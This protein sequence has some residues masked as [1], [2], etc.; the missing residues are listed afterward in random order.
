MRRKSAA[1]KSVGPFSA[2][3]VFENGMPSSPFVQA[4]MKMAQ[5][6]VASVVDR[7][8]NRVIK[9]A[10]TMSAVTTKYFVEAS[11]AAAD[12]GLVLGQIYDIS[13]GSTDE[14]EIQMRAKF[15]VT[16]TEGEMV[17]ER[18]ML[19]I[20]QDWRGKL[21]MRVHAF[22]ELPDGTVV[23]VYA[24]SMGEGESVEAVVAS[25]K[26][27]KE[28]GQPDGEGQK[29]ET[30]AAESMVIDAEVVETRPEPVVEEQKKKHVYEEEKSKR[31][32]P[33]K[34]DKD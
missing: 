10:E 2:G 23:D 13:E 1:T 16:T 17:S 27:S 25:V 21:V 24:K 28:D 9:N 4:M 6:A 5:P 29:S 33:R 7:M 32:R 12:K 14:A 18:G 31:G 22:Y 30:R 3:A 34:K 8:M 20:T 15:A 19:R 11:E 26:D